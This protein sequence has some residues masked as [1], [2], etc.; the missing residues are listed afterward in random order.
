MAEEPILASSTPVR[1]PRDPSLWLPWVF[2]VI[3]LAVAVPVLLG[4]TRPAGEPRTWPGVAEAA[5][6]IDSLPPQA[7][8]QVLWAYDP[9]TAGELDLVA[10]PVLRQLL[11]RGVQLDIVSLLPAGPATARRLVTRL[12]EEQR[13][14][15]LYRSALPPVNPR[16][17]PGGATV[18]PLLGLQTADLAVV[19]AARAEDVQQWLEFVA[20]ANRV[21]VV[22]VTAAGADPPLR[23]YWESGQLAGLVSGFDGA[24][25]LTRLDTE[26]PTR[27]A[28][29]RLRTQIVGENFALVALL[30]VILAGNLAALLSGRRRDG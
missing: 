9:A 16:F 25:A 22:A 4:L 21:P 18:L 11:A 5:A 12:Q 10:A 30:G 3:G 26:L 28:E 20:P 23:P 6:A 2:W 24:Y 17:L 27:V 29:V 15:D 8:V 1:P 19:F 13:T 14:Q 7:T